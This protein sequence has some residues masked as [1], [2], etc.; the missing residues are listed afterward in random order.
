MLACFVL[1]RCLLGPFLCIVGFHCYVFCLLVVLV[2][3][4]VL[5]KWLT[6]KTSLRKPNHGEESSPESPGRRVHMIFLVYCIVSLFYCVCVV[7]WPYMIYFPNAMARYILF[8]LKVPLNTKQTFNYLK[9]KGLETVQRESAAHV[10]NNKHQI[11]A[12]VFSITFF[13]SIYVGGFI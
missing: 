6:R 3:L 2:K 10:V 5:A 12:L 7:S 11:V 8:V 9:L 13:S 1:Y 4:S